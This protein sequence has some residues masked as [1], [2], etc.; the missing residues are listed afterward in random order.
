[1][2]ESALLGHNGAPTYETRGDLP[3]DLPPLEWFKC[4][5]KEFLDDLL[6]LPLDE[7][8]F[9]ASAVMVMYAEM[10]TLPADDRMA[11]HR[12]A[13]DVRS[14]RAMI[15]KLME[16]RSTTSQ[17]PLLYKRPSGRVSNHRYDAE[18][19]AYVES[20]KK[21]R[22]AAS[23]REAKR[24]SKPQS[25]AATSLRDVLGMSDGS[26]DIPRTSKGHS[27][28]N[29]KQIVYTSSE[30]NKEN[31]W[32]MHQLPTT[33]LAEP[34][35]TTATDREREVEREVERDNTPQPPKGGAGADLI[36]EQ[37]EI[38]WKT[39]PAS[40]RK[41]AKGECAM[42][43]RQAVTGFRHKG[44]KGQKLAEHGQVTAEQL[45][46]AVR[47]YAQTHPDPRY[48]PAPATWLNQG[49][50]LD[51]PKAQPQPLG[52][53]NGN[54]H[55]YANGHANGHAAGEQKRADPWW[56]KGKEDKVR[57]LPLAVWRKAIE[58]YGQAHWAEEY[59]GP[60]PGAEGCLVASEIVAELG[61]TAKYS[62]AGGL[63][64]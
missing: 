50:W 4:N 11:A 49:R 29:V 7:R 31:Q 57:K 28:S 16:R 43:F 18:I 12:L 41:V 19:T 32:S 8:G 60:P 56:W 36:D 55:S 22:E 23:D 46:D 25:N 44:R 27:T 30:K 5:A 1:M 14:Y 54:G 15:R 20:V 61:L 52:H 37:F 33:V 10:E 62:A 26:G 2:N 9:F 48:V 35:Q 24:R 6:R 59:L 53:V 38:W 39:F 63:L 51:E 58:T 45:I 42:L 40:V 47:R 3:N 34:C 21:R 13:M 64:L 17:R